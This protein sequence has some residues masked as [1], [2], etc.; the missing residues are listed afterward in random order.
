M[1]I[2]RRD[3]VLDQADFFNALLQLGSS[4]AETPAW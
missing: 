3:D 2:A 4:H 1:R